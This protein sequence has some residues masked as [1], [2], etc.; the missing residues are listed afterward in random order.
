[1]P[2]NGAPLPLP[3]L[4]LTQ[5][6]LCSAILKTPAHFGPSHLH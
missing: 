2:H 5:G 3:L 6:L 1:M 4:G